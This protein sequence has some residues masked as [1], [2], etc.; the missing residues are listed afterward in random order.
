MIH[1]TLPCRRSDSGMRLARLPS[2]EQL[3]EDLATLVIEGIPW[4]LVVLN[5]N[6]RI[7]HSNEA[8]RRL[9][10]LEAPALKG[11]EF[12]EIAAGLFGQTAQLNEELETLGNSHD[13][14]ACLSMEQQAGNQ[15]SR[16]FWVRGRRL[17]STL[18]EYWMITFEDVTAH[19]ETQRQLI[20]TTMAFERIQEEERRRIARD[21]H[22]D[23]TQRLV[24]M[25]MDIGAVEE[26]ISTAAR[27]RLHEVRIRLG[28]LASDVSRLAHHLHPAIVED[29]G[30]A[31]ALRTIVQEF[32]RHGQITATFSSTNVPERIALEAATAHGQRDA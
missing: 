2:E 24:S 25:D 12:A 17:P 19:K 32:D 21:L 11:R 9:S 22:D 15:D 29:L 14:G 30:L 31:A 28:S 27:A 8:F 4:P 5:W 16:V 1:D 6:F 23:V 10:R 26:M 3:R 7:C 13:D 18:A 20:S